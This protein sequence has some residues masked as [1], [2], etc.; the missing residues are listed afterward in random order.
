MLILGSVA[1]DEFLS[2]TIIQ[3]PFV[4]TAIQAYRQNYT[5]LYRAYSD[6]SGSTANQTDLQCI[7]VTYALGAIDNGFEVVTR[8]DTDLHTGDS[9]AFLTVRL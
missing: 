2:T 8:F 7:E 4:S 6:G 5:Q 3:G 9:G 1:V